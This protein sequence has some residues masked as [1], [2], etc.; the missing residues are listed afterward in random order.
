VNPVSEC[1]QPITYGS[2]EE[3]HPFTPPAAFGGT[4]SE[5]GAESS[6]LTPHSSLLSTLL[7]KTKTPSSL[8]GSDGVFISARLSIDAAEC[9]F[10][11]G[12]KQKGA[13][14]MQELAGYYDGANVQLLNGSAIHL[15]KNQRLKIL[16]MNDFMEDTK[17]GAKELNTEQFD[18]ENARRAFDRLLSH[19][20]PGIGSG[21]YKAD[22]TE[23]LEKRYAAID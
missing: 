18:R 2:I 11:N 10:Y 14:A 17:L 16:V 19:A 7:S 5:K 15:K 9:R 3:F 22:L 1:M 6:L 21:D 13:T 12:G 8:Y 23:M 20:K 4:P